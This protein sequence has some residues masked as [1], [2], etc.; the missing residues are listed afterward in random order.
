MRRG[1]AEVRASVP[2]RGEYGVLGSDAMDAAVLH[3]H[4]DDT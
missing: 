4:T 3:I 1:A 2:A